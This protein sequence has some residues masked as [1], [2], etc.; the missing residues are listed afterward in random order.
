[1]GTIETSA[2]YKLDA[3][4]AK[5]KAT[6]EAEAGVLVVAVVDAIKST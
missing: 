1:M 5:D 3:E 2:G 4:T 6:V